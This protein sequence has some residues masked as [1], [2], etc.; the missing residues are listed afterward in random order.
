M[1]DIKNIY[2]ESQYQKMYGEPGAKKKI[3]NKHG[4]QGPGTA[5]SNKKEQAIKGIWVSQ[6]ITIYQGGYLPF[7]DGPKSDHRLLWIKISHRIAFGK[8]KASYRALAARRLR[9]DHI[10]DQNKY[11]TKLILLTRENNVFQKFR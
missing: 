2:P 8:N 1:G 9:L 11:T 5:I 6:G 7:H 3:T 10:R 4:G